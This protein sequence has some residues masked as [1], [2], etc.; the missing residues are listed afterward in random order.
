MYLLVYPS[1]SATQRTKSLVAG[2][3]P[4]A[5]RLDF[6]TPDGQLVPRA[7]GEAALLGHTAV[8]VGGLFVGMW[9]QL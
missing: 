3:R 5:A 7:A 4:G 9:S 2:P 6:I 1:L 8:L